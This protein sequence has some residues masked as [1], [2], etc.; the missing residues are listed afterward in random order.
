MLTAILVAQLFIVLILIA[1]GVTLDN[2]KK[3]VLAFVAELQK[4]DSEDIDNK[5]NGAEEDKN[6]A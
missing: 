4:E 3:E 6:N 1:I 5:E 2:I